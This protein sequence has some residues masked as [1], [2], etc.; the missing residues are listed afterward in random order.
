[1]FLILLSC[2]QF[3]FIYL[4]E[5]FRRVDWPLSPARDGNT[6]VHLYSISHL[7]HL[8]GRLCSIYQTGKCYKLQDRDI[9]RPLRAS[10]MHRFAGTD[11][12]CS[13]KCGKTP[14][15]AINFDVKTQDCAMEPLLSTICSYCQQ[16]VADWHATHTQ[17]HTYAPVLP[18][19]RARGC[20][21]PCRNADRWVP[22][23]GTVRHSQASQLTGS[24]KM[25]K[26]RRAHQLEVNI[27]SVHIV[28][29]LVPLRPSPRILSVLS[30]PCWSLWKTW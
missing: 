24:N 5:A 14:C 17:T 30:L 27:P 16:S 15:R 1:M 21:W 29:L 2:D 25:L 18:S 26:D 13:Q 10:I 7:N 9:L 12:H 3:G 20:G 23:G 22:S 4:F 8:C 6:I 28:S 19:T 11:G